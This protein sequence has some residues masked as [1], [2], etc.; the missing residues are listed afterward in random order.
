MEAYPVDLCAQEE[1]EPVRRGTS[2]SQ[3]ARS[4]GVDRSTL[5]RYLKRLHE[6]GPL[7]PKKRPRALLR[8]WRER[9]APA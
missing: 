3:T 6:D 5:G 9:Q 8:S 1:V 4:F 2:N 7:A